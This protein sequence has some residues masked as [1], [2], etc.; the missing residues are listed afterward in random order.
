MGEPCFLPTSFHYSYVVIQRFCKKGCNLNHSR[1][2]HL[3]HPYL[4]NTNRSL[5]KYNSTEGNYLCDPDT[6]QRSWEFSCISQRIC[7][8]SFFHL[9][10][11]VY[12]IKSWSKVFRWQRKK[13]VNT[14]VNSPPIVFIIKMIK[15]GCK[16]QEL[17][18]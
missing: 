2:I 9:L 15:N 13:E 14:S 3:D 8:L 16:S 18:S 10:Q 6:K 12:K 11:W 17:F 5:S 4:D 7:F 1:L